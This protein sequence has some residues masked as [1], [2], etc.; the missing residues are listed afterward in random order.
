M[1]NQ[2]KNSIDA[3]LAESF[4]EIAG[5]K[6][7]EKITIK[8]ITDR[9]G[10]IRPTFYNHFQDKYELLEWILEREVI[11]LI[12]PA[13]EAGDLKAGVVAA[14]ETVIRDKAFY[15]NAARLEGQNSFKEILFSVVRKLILS[16]LDVDDMRQKMPYSWLTPEVCASFISSSICFAVIS[17]I[18]G[19]MEI[20]VDEIVD[21]FIYMSYHSTLEM[22]IPGG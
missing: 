7:I 15:V 10:V 6:S 16:Y 1:S 21:T 4:K 13:V 18:K 20:P 2:G 12:P 5:S 17:W 22:L 9:A 3:L 19:G 11:A 8:E 14:M